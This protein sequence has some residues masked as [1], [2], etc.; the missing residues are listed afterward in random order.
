MRIAFYGWRTRNP[1]DVVTVAFG[2][3]HVSA[4]DKSDAVF[5]EVGLS[6]QT[7]FLSKQGNGQAEEETK[8]EDMGA[9]TQVHS[10]WIRG[11]EGKQSAGKAGLLASTF[12]Q[13]AGFNR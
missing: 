3:P 1:A 10:G 5:A 7:G 4:V 8:E 12:C 9:R 13:T 2:R 11:N 6:E